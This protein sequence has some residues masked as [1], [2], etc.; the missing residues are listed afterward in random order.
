MDGLLIL[1]VT[2]PPVCSGDSARVEA[3]PHSGCLLILIGTLREVSAYGCRAHC[4]SV[5]GVWMS[6]PLTDTW[7]VGRKYMGG[8][9][10]NNRTHVKAF[11]P[12]T[13]LKSRCGQLGSGQLACM[14]VHD[15]RCGVAGASTH[16]TAAGHNMVH[17]QRLALHARDQEIQ[18][19]VDEDDVGK[20][21]QPRERVLARHVQSTCRGAVQKFGCGS[22]GAAEAVVACQSLV[23]LAQRIHGDYIMACAAAPAAAVPAAARACARCLH[24][25]MRFLQFMLQPRNLPLEQ[26]LLRR[27]V[28]CQPLQLRLLLVQHLTGFPQLRLQRW[29][30]APLHTAGNAVQGW[31]QR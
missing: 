25:R 20:H 21:N 13:Q 3:V 9:L 11:H 12:P 24:C 15:S 19:Q 10:C 31:A 2:V 22:D 8:A 4:L 30:G 17:H 5:E 27:T 23:R 28:G 7:R 14:H 16:C 26:H 18:V 1:S 29:R 6:A